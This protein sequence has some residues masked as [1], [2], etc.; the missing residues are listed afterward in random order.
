MPEKTSS[1]KRPSIEESGEMAVDFEFT[2]KTPQMNSR[3]ETKLCNISCLTRTAM[4]DANIPDELRYSIFMMFFKWCCQTDQLTVVTIN[5][6]SKS[7]HEHMSGKLPNWVHHMQI[8]GMAG[9][10]KTHTKTNTKVVPRGK[11]CMF[12]GYAADH[13]GGCHVMFDPKWR[14][15]LKSRDVLWLNRMYF[16]NRDGQGA[17]IL[18]EGLSIEPSDE[19]SNDDE[20]TVASIENES[21]DDSDDESEESEESEDNISED[22]DD[23]EDDDD[24]DE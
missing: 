1:Y 8:A 4:E 14:S 6:V 19:G 17:P 7:R 11:T 21:D 20:S 22:E 16:P 10:V 13:A 18:T 15:T 12:V 3:V 23:D 9:V 5:G 24:D 2:A